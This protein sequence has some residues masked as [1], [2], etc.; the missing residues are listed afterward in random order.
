MSI[1]INALI[2]NAN[3]PIVNIDSGAVKNHNAGRMNAFIMPRTVA[4]SRKAKKFLALIPGTINVAKPR[5]TA[6]AN[7]AMSMAFKS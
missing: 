7:Q 1:I 6:V 3:R 5:P 4:A 2:T